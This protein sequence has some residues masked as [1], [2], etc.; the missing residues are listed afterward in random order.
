MMTTTAQTDEEILESQLRKKLETMSELIFAKDLSV[1][2][3]LWSGGSFW[4]FGSEE[5]EHDETREELQRHMT[6]LLHKPYRYT[7][8]TV[9]ALHSI[10]SSG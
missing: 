10:G 7:S 9:C 2:E 4:L 5:H 3:E 1:V 6:A 8:P